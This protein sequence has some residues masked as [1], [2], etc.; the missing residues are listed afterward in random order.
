MK[1]KGWQ[2]ENRVT[3][4]SNNFIFSV[5]FS[6]SKIFFETPTHGSDLKVPSL[7]AMYV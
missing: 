7:G 2:F 5:V 6:L 1:I 3:N 4:Q